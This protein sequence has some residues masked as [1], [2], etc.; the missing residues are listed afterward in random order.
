MK[1]SILFND[2]LNCIIGFLTK[3]SLLMHIQIMKV[4][5]SK[6]AVTSI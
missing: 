2:I 3:K 5:F 4:N 6:V 1:I